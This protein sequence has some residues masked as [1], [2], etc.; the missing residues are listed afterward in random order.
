MAY[1]APRTAFDLDQGKL[2]KGAFVL[3][4]DLDLGHNTFRATSIVVEK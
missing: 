3:A 2:E 4:V 1:N